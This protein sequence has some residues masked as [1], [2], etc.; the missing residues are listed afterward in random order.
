MTN[1]KN[2]VFYK[3]NPKQVWPRRYKISKNVETSLNLMGRCNR[4][5]CS[6]LKLSGLNWRKTIKI[7]IGI[8]K[9]SKIGGR[10]LESTIKI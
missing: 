6:A 2:S 9:L 3:L 5:K 4:I 10:V 8:L 1:K 7:D